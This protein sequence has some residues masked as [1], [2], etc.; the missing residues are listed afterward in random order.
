MLKCSMGWQAGKL[1]ELGLGAKAAAALAAAG[2]YDGEADGAAGGPG[3]SAFQV[4][5]KGE[6][7]GE[8]RDNA[9]CC[10]SRMRLWMSCVGSCKRVL[11][12]ATVWPV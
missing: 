12:T 3:G 10:H 8:A 6:K 9:A 7:G 5:K 4:R 1:K 2:A 11:H